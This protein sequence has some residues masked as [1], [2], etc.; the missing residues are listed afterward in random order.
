MMSQRL[1]R[2]ERW[3]AGKIRSCRAAGVATVVAVSLSLLPL[4]MAMATDATTQLSV[5]IARQSLESALVELSK[6]GHLQLVIATNALPAKMSASLRGSMPLGV[7]LDHLLKDTGLTYRVV[8]DHTIAIVKATEVHRQLSDPPASPGVSGAKSSGAPDRD[9]K[10]EE[11]VQANNA[12]KGDHPVSHRSLMS[13]LATFLGICVSASAGGPACAQDAPPSSAHQL[14]EIVVTARK[15]EESL[16]SVPVAVAVI[17]EKQLQNGNAS[18]LTKVAELAPQV[19]MSQSGSGTGAV[20]TIRG[21]SSGSNDAGLDQS[22]A[23]EVDGIPISRGQILSSAIFDLKQ[24]EVLQGPQALFF[25]K[26]SPAGVI[27]LS[28]ANPTDK[29]E[30]YVTPGYEFEADQR[31]VE[32]A[33]SGPVSDTLKA[34]VAFRASKM[35]GWIRNVAAPVRDFINPTVTDPGATMGRE[36]PDDQIY[37]GRVTL[38]WT[39]TD[40]FDANLKFT[41]NSQERNAGNA[42][43]EPF[44]ING[45]TQPTLVGGVPLPGADCS[46]NQQKATG[47]VAPVYALN[48]PYSNGGVPYLDSRYTLTSLNLNQRF[49]ALTLTSTTGYYDQSVQQMSVSD[50]SPYATIWAASRESY[51]LFTQELRARSEFDSPVNFM[52]GAYY[53]NFDRPFFNSADLFHVFNPAANNYAIVEMASKSKGSYLS[54]FA[55]VR[56]N[57]LPE[58]ELAGGARYSHDEKD[59]RIVNIA[60]TPSPTYATLYP[61][62]QPLTSK[63]KDDNVSPE[64]TL[65]WHPVDNQ[66]LYGAYKTGYKAGGMSNPYLLFT[67]TN[68]QNL[69]FQPEEAKGFEAGYKATVLDRTLRFDLVAYR[70]KYNDLQVATYNAQTISFT[71][72]NAASARIEGVQGSFEW[73]ALD[74]LTLHGNFGYNRARYENYS[75]A[76]CFAGQTL[77]QGCVGT[78]TNRTQNLADK[79]LLRAPDLTY[80][81]GA[82]YVARWIPGWDTT[83]SVTGTHTGSYQTAT[84]YAPGGFQKSFWLLNAAVRTGPQDGRY[85]IALIGRDLTNSYYMLNVNGWS[86]AGNTS[87]QFVGFFNRPREIVLQATARF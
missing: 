1:T 59:T 56:W 69:Q 25:G 15:T 7:A 29:F 77:A 78:G 84:D 8:G 19:S 54:G 52:V 82:D 30:G 44:C 9:L 2:W 74:D 60:K 18:D 22:V 5:D 14:G 79:P 32:G 31:F 63:Y 87:N 42:S 57:I 26:N 53:E 27:S 37:S 50:W 51:T 3:L 17:S 36:G 34:R 70:Y 11:G 49:S 62:G 48:T 83:F 4:H 86:G 40:S 23:I 75:N 24:V 76:Q 64:A 68:A 61:I 10:V 20:I 38:L 55:Q 47:S 80:S 45:Q 13:R 28:S 43:S 41:L 73:S 65:T 71:I 12:D 46:R 85:E 67:S 66:T 72:N 81:L 35:N 39:P 58:L 33:L 16:Q 6:Q 21:V